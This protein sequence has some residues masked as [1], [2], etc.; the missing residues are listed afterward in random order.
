ML[1]WAI[2]DTLGFSSA[3]VVKRV[4]RLAF[5]AIKSILLAS[6]AAVAEAS[7]EGGRQPRIVALVVPVCAVA[8]SLALEGHALGGTRAPDVVAVEVDDSESH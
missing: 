8:E 7:A 3:G 6:D 2:L 5:F 1:H 4:A